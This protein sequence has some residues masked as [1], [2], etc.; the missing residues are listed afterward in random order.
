MIPA[1]KAWYEVKFVDGETE[2]AAFYK[3]AGESFEKPADLKKAG[4]IFKG[5][6]TAADST[7]VV[8]VVTTPTETVTYYAVWEEL[9]L[10][11]VT[12][13]DPAYT[14]TDLYTFSNIVDAY[15]ATKEG[16]TI[17]IKAGTYKDALV[18]EKSVVIAGPNADKAG[19]ATDRAEEAKFEGTML[20]NADNVTIKGIAF[21]GHDAKIAANISGTERSATVIV[22]AGKNFEFVNNYVT[23]GK[24]IVFEFGT[25]EDVKFD[26]NFF[27]WTKELGATGAWAWRP[28]RMDGK[29]TNLDFTNN[30]IIQTADDDTSAGLYDIVYI[31]N[32]AGIININNNDIVGYSYNWNFNIANAAE[33]TEI[34]FNNNIVDGP[35]DAGSTTINVGTMGKNTSA[36]FKDNTVNTAGTT[37]SYDI[38]DAD[39]AEYAGTITITGNTFNSSAY[40]PRIKDAVAAANVVHTG[41]V[42]KAGAVTATGSFTFTMDGNTAE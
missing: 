7:E 16:G 23:S 12:T 15:F 41:N 31:Q 40:K 42:I 22:T 9:P 27:N 29:V 39:L 26:S 14:G 10:A 21:T 34:N 18:I 36:N 20:I 17:N 28:I 5:W 38:K 13:V 6:A 37:Y 25:V 3:D 35:E 24:A 32:A 4:Y 19:N 2:L 1:E 11:D 33:C 8:E 30:K